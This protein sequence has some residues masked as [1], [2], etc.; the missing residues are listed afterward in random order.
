MNTQSAKA[1]ALRTHRAIRSG[2]V[3]G[4][5]LD[6]F[7]LAAAGQL[8][9]QSGRCWP[10]LTDYEAAAWLGVG[11]ST[12]NSA[13]K[14]LVDRGLVVKCRRRP[15]RFKPSGQDVWGWRLATSAEGTR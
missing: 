3:V 2:T 7:R 9:D 4:R 15:C 1:D 12:I 6:H 10:D 11:R 5:L 14:E 8:A 13:R